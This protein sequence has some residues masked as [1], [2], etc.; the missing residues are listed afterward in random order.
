MTSSLP[1]RPR[2]QSTG[3]IRG[4]EDEDLRSI[5]ETV[6]S[7][8]MSTLGFTSSDSVLSS[9]T[10]SVRT[11]SR[12]RGK[13]KNPMKEW[14][15]ESSMNYIVAKG[16][17]LLEDIRSLL[18][19]Q[20]MK[21]KDLDSTMCAQMEVAKSKYLT[22]NIPG[23]V[24]CMKQVRE[25]QKQQK[26]AMSAIEFLQNQEI[27]LMTRIEEVQDTRALAKIGID[28]ASTKLSSQLT[29]ELYSSFAF[30]LSLCD[31]YSEHVATIYSSQPQTNDDPD[32]NALLEELKKALPQT[33]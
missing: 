14:S 25:L 28:E 19:T 6:H 1:R 16:N 23:A 29:S 5:D 13:S 18:G 27:N 33:F 15:V 9:E 24:R 20:K 30:E 7:S 10:G 3:K 2:K 32:N 4:K 21:V 22:N 12:K 26:K 31:N 17:Q 11:R 8:E